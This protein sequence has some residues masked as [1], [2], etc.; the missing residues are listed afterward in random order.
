ME[1]TNKP[2][3]CPILSAKISSQSIEKLPVIIQMKDNNA[4]NINNLAYGLKGEKKK[5]LPLIKGIAC[6]LTTD[7]IYKLAEDPNIEYISFDSKVFALLDVATKS[8]DSKY[9]H[10]QGYLGQGITIAVVDTG[11][12]PHNDLIKP[13]NRI[14][15]FK[16]FVN[17]KTTPYDDNGHGTHVS[18][19]LAG[20]GYSSQKKYQ[21]VAPEASILGVKVLDESGSGNTS[22]IIDAISWIIKTKNEYNT[23]I[24][25]LSLG[26]PANNPCSS[27]PLCKAVEQAVNNGICVVVAA[28]NSGPASKTILSPGISPNVITVGAMNDRRTSGTPK[29]TIPSFSSR[30]PTKEGL[31]K[32]DLVAP[33]V[34]IMSL[35]NT[36][37]DGYISLS[38]T[39]M[40][41]P[42]VSGSIALILQKQKNLSPKE[43]KNI[44]MDSCVDL[45]DNQENQGSG[46]VN[47][48]KIFHSSQENNLENSLEK[49]TPFSN[50]PHKDNFT[51]K[52]IILLI[53]F[54]LL[55]RNV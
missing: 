50:Y 38:G 1:K 16:D 39:S 17:N 49:E 34:N 25:N 8:I 19:I 54:L 2:K 26:S 7:L 32:P 47:L 4:D 27:D 36:R 43:I 55:D 6:N 11:V 45:K 44:L 51:E 3:L 52:I 28:G 23:K 13:N 22:D 10:D 20:N 33:G 18:G 35:S 29:N 24:I 41:T 46:M 15:G 5:E 9:P 48:K 21:G 14:V 40:A 53:I 31:N 37:L 30:G 12:A 42:L